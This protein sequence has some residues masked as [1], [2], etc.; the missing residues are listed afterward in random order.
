MCCILNHCTEHGWT[1]CLQTFPII[2]IIDPTPQCWPAH[3]CISSSAADQLRIGN[4]QTDKLEPTISLPRSNFECL[5]KHGESSEFPPWRYLA[6]YMARYLEISGEISGDIWRE[7]TFEPWLSSVLRGFISWG[8][9][10]AADDV[11][12]QR[13]PVAR[14]DD[15]AAPKLSKEKRIQRREKQTM[16]C[17]KGTFSLQMRGKVGK[18]ECPTSHYNFPIVQCGGFKML[19]IPFG[20][21]SKEYLRSGLS[22]PI[23]QLGV[24][25]GHNITKRNLKDLVL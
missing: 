14:N 1:N 8:S 9:L 11:G 24:C 12:R 25:R 22:Q 7:I 5:A 21:T 15:A 10:P 18:Y 13:E 3:I 16:H 19:C 6:R 20:L 4:W 23:L 2:I 17:L